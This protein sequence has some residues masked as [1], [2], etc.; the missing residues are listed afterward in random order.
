MHALTLLPP[1]P[2]PL[3]QIASLPPEDR[4]YGMDDRAYRIHWNEGQNKVDTASIAGAAV[5]AALA[6]TA[7]E[8]TAA[9]VAGGAALGVVG[10]LGYYAASAYQSETPAAHGK[11]KKAT[12]Q[13]A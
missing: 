2:S 3:T 5:G 7:V 6:A 4:Q 11:G 13:A 1:R 10:G 8:A 9:V 12:P